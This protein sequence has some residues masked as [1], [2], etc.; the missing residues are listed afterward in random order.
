MCLRPCTFVSRVRRRR[1]TQ[2][3]G[4]RETLRA[5]RARLAALSRQQECPDP[6]AAVPSSAPCSRPLRRIQDRSRTWRSMRRRA[7]HP[8]ICTQ[9]RRRPPPRNREQQTHPAPPAVQQ[10]AT[11][12]TQICWKLEWRRCGTRTAWLPGACL[13]P[14]RPLHPARQRLPAGRANMTTLAACTMLRAC[15]GCD[16]QDPD[17]MYDPE[18]DDKDDAWMHRQ[19]QGRET[20]AL[21][22]CPGCFTTVCIDCQ[23]VR[24]W[25]ACLAALPRV[26]HHRLHRLPAGAG[27][28][29]AAGAR[30]GHRVRPPARPLSFRGAQ[31]RP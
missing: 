22:S 27:A 23:Q 12:K 9:H 18:A 21:L 6:L 24:A 7:A 2:R 14:P 25:H 20:D 10:T 3:P 29:H 19:R 1:Q 17:P 5:A 30:L 11:V 28:A 15:G 16:A 4:P 26:L 8:N 31:L 13:P